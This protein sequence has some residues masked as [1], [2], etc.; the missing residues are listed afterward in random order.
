MAHEAVAAIEALKTD[1][2]HDDLPARVAR[3]H[4]F[5]LPAWLQ[6]ATVLSAGAWA[7]V[8]VCARLNPAAFPDGFLEDNLLDIAANIAIALFAGAL[9]IALYKAEE[10]SS[11]RTPFLTTAY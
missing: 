10:L 4:P 1:A 3:R 9:T 8:L 7:I 5:R 2:A 6:F 11:P